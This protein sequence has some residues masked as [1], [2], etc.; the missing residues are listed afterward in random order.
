MFLATVGMDL[1][2]GGRVHSDRGEGGLVTLVLIRDQ[3]VA[4]SGRRNGW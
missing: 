4:R 2:P 3:D 1:R